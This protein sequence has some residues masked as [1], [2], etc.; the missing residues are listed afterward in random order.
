[1]RPTGEIRAAIFKALKMGPATSKVLAGRACTG[2]DA[3]RRTLD[4][5]VR[6]QHARVL[7]LARVPGVKRPVPVY[8]LPGM[9]LQLGLFDQAGVRQ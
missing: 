8:G 1:M 5:M 2:V 4:N 3:T 6:G 9:G 7:H